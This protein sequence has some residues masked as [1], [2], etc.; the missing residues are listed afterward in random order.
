M[1]FN[2]FLIEK[3]N[4]NDGK[5]IIKKDRSKAVLFAKIDLTGTL[6]TRKLM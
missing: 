4:F 3:L 5:L 6:V 1:S 2:S